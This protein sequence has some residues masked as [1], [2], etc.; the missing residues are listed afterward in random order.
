MVTQQRR[1]AP[2]FGPSWPEVAGFGEVSPTSNFYVLAA[3]Q[4]CENVRLWPQSPCLRVCGIPENHAIQKAL[5]KYRV[6]IYT[7]NQ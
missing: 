3:R 2:D 5:D 6:E 4:K 7:V 1:N